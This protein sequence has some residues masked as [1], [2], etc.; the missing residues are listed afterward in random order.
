MKKVLVLFATLITTAVFAQEV[1]TALKDGEITV[2][3]KDGTVHKFSENEYA[4]VKRKSKPVELS[5]PTPMVVR[6]APTKNRITVHAG[7]GFY[8]LNIERSPDDVLVREQRRAVLGLS[9]SRRL[10]E[11]ISLGVSAFTNST[12]TLDAGLDF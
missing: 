1:P 6:I 3:L 7:I 12:F 8:G 11:D 4:V 2:I 5:K 9:Y 10:N